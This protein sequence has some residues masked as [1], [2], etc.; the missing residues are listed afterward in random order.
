M[1][2]EVAPEDLVRRFAGQRDRRSFA[3]RL[4]Q[5]IERGV[6]IPET[7]RQ[8]A[9]THDLAPDVE[10]GE[11]LVVEDD[12]GVVRADMLGDI[13]GVGCVPARAHVVRRE[14]RRPG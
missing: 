10:V 4:E 8:I 7:H 6:H 1:E 2:L 14:V 9:G 11:R 3:D 13:V 5:Q 12:V